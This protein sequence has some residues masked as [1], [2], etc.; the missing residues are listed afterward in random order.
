MKTSV[1]SK[2]KI[3]RSVRPYHRCALPAYDFGVYKVWNPAVWRCPSDLILEH[4]RRHTGPSHMDIGCGTGYL[5]D[6][7]NRSAFDRLV[8]VD[9]S[10]HSLAWS[11]KRLRRYHPEMVKHNIL[12]PMP[13]QIG[14]FDSISVNYVLH[15]LPTTLKEKCGVIA[16]LTRCLAEDGVVFGTTISGRYSQH[17]IRAKGMLWL[18]NHIGSF[19]NA[20]DSAAELEKCLKQDY[21][22]VSVRQIGS[23]IFFSARRNAAD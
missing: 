20:F 7:L 21:R 8:L 10:P 9:L 12:V 4:Y 5:L 23:V 2:R 3:E 1:P 6:R 19:T 11:R 17:S 14:V 18:Y 13:Q 16:G 22:D 15:C